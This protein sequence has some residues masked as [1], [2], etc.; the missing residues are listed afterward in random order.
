MEEDLVA[1]LRTGRLPEKF[2]RGHV[3]VTQEEAQR[4]GLPCGGKELVLERL[5]AQRR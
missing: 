4:I 3:W 5:E 1:R 2:R